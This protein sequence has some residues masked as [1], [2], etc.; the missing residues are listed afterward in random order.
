MQRE[1]SANDDD[2]P[3][4]LSDAKQAREPNV[5]AQSD[6]KRKLSVEKAA[7]VIRDAY[8]SQKA[9]KNPNLPVFKRPAAAPPATAN[10]A[11]S[12]PAF[13]RPAAAP[14]AALEESSLPAKLLPLVAHESSRNQ[15]LARM[16]KTIK[17]HRSKIFK[18]HSKTDM[19]RALREAS[20]YCFFVCKSLKIKLKDGHVF[21]KSV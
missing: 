6:S 18:Y 10:A 19:T 12:L 7:Q 20:D 15:Y 13:K 5:T 17:D 14:G 16:P 2:E 8:T 3:A 1:V 4:A 21:R 9:P 11:K